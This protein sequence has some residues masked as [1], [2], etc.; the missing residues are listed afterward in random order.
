[1]AVNKFKFALNSLIEEEYGT[2]DAI[3]TKKLEKEK[4]KEKEKPKEKPKEKGK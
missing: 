1:M 4:E 3:T 2:K